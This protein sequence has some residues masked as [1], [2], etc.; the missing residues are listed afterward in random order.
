[1]DISRRF[2]SDDFLGEARAEGL[3]G[4]GADDKADCDKRQNRNSR[5]RTP[6][7]VKTRQHVRALTD[8]TDY[9]LR[10][11]IFFVNTYAEKGTLP[12]YTFL[13]CSYRD[14]MIYASRD[15]HRNGWSSGRRQ[16]A[17]ESN[18]KNTKTKIKR[19]SSL[20]L[21]EGSRGFP[22]RLPRFERGGIPRPSRRR[23]LSVR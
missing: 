12:D 22:R 6:E 16:A 9:R 13:G 7:G 2:R 3:A 18:K 10:V 5:K 19:I 1:M 17:M 8:F 4:G 21:T 20:A 14:V 23:R 11:I 15:R